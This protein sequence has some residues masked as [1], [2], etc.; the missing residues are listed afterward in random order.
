M[1]LLCVD[2]QYPT[3]VLFYS[4]NNMI[5]SVSVINSDSNSAAYCE[6]LHVRGSR[7]L[8]YNVSKFGR[9]LIRCENSWSVA[10]RWEFILVF[11]S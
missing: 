11:G 3:C 9:S 8:F 10:Q 4:L 5:S 2:H 1:K 7:A 6:Q